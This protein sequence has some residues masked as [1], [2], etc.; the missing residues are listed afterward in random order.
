MNKTEFDIENEY[1]Y[2]KG[3]LRNLSC[4]LRR[5][6]IHIIHSGISIYDLYTIQENNFE[7]KVKLRSKSKTALLNKNK[8]PESTLND[9]YKT[10][11]VKTL[12]PSSRIDLNTTSIKYLPSNHTNK[13]KDIP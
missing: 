9:S 7:H 3:L 11:F 10:K 5:P 4:V 6:P 2:V 12:K 13:Q 8:S 1:I